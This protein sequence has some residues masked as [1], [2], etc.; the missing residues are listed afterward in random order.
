MSSHYFKK[1]SDVFLCDVYK[2]AFRIAWEVPLGTRVCVFS[3]C[4]LFALFCLRIL[5][6]ISWCFGCQ[7]T[8]GT[9]HESHWIFFFSS[10]MKKDEVFWSCGSQLIWLLWLFF[11]FFPQNTKRVAKN[12]FRFYFYLSWCIDFG[13]VQKRS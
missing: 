12:V 6:F 10:K 8:H 2:K 4:M 9:T 13:L 7:K 3:V 11:C 5:F 1:Y